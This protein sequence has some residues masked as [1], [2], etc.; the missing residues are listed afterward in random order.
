MH[1][2]FNVNVTGIVPTWNCFSSFQSSLSQLFRDLTTAVEVASSVLYERQPWCFCPCSI[3]RYFNIFKMTYVN[4]IW[5]DNYICDMKSG[6][7]LVNSVL[8]YKRP[9]CGWGVIRAELH[10]PLTKIMWCHFNLTSGLF[11]HPASFSSGFALSC[12][13][14]LGPFGPEAM[15]FPTL[16]I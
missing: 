5:N 4:N 7:C 8:F 14:A 13:V 3:N 9:V 2:H 1:L 16:F 15:L 11:L 12:A 10:W 6:N